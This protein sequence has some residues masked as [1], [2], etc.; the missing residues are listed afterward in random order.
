MAL[1]LLELHERMHLYIVMFY[2]GCQG[3]QLKW[4]ITDLRR[5]IRL[6]TYYSILNIIN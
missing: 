2:Y 1:F 4:Q 6:E 5:Y 3:K